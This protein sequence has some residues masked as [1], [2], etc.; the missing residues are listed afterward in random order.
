MFLHYHK[1]YISLFSDKYMTNEREEQLFRDYVDNMLKPNS[2]EYDSEAHSL[3]G[4][5][6]GFF[7][8]NPAG[9]RAFLNK[10]QLEVN[11]IRTRGMREAEEMSRIHA[12]ALEENRKY[13]ARLR[14][15]KMQTGSGLEE[16]ASKFQRDRAF[17]SGDY[18]GFVGLCNESGYMPDGEAEEEA[19]KQ[20]CFL[21]EQ[22]KGDEK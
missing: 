19:Y 15:K 6:F 20:G 1:V 8:G 18:V 2:E 9:Q 7:R 13:D 5:L 3:N 4:R 17:S 16:Q 11:R 10:V 14:N 12:E 22:E 21:I